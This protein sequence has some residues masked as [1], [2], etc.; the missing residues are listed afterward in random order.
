MA[1]YLSI[2]PTEGESKA[3]ALVTSVYV[4]SELCD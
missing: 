4:V 3:S 1:C 2:A